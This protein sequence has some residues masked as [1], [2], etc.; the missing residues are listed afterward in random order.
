MEEL[1]SNMQDLNMKIANTDQCA[2]L[3]MP[4][5]ERKVMIQSTQHKLADPVEPLEQTLHTTLKSVE[6]AWC[7]Q[8]KREQEKYN[9]IV[10]EHT[11]LQK[12]HLS[13]TGEHERVRSERDESTQGKLD[14]AC[15]HT[16]T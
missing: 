3:E 16:G 8:T 9:R 7:E 1:T 11:Q 14:F 4:N 10:A 6:K 2:D 13:L 5:R 15:Y 12:D